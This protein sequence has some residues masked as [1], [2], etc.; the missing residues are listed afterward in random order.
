MSC[1]P[2][3]LTLALFLPLIAPAAETETNAPFEFLVMGCMPYHMPK[4]EA[5]FQN[6]IAIA[7]QAR[8]AFSVHCGDTKYGQVP[9][10]DPAYDQIKKRFDQFQHPFIYTPGDN[11]W[12]DCHTANAGQFDPLDRLALVRRL[13]FPDSQSL[14]TPSLTLTS[15]PSQQP[16]FATY[17]E[18]NR[19]SHNSILFTTLHVVGSNNNA[20]ENHPAAMEEFIARDAASIAWMQAAFKEAANPEHRALVLFMQANP[21]SETQRSEPRSPGFANIVPALRAAV[22]AF[23]KPVYLFHSDS[24]YFRIDQPLTSPTGRTL[25]NFTRIETFGGHNLHL[26]RVQV[27][28]QSPTPL[29]ASPLIIEANLVNPDLPLPGKKK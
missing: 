9:C 19:W 11:E 27:N 3:L 16:Q 24:H 17:V 18:N 12:T 1:R 25:E 23:P 2:L 28:P 22:Q 29:T 7:N 20:R 26:I 8:P 15:Q 13:F 6:I 10:D 5:R 21:L 4:D 14:G